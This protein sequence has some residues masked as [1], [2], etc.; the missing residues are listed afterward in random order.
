MQEKNLLTSKMLNSE[1]QGCMK[2][3]S[4][5][6]KTLIQRN[7]IDNQTQLTTNKNLQIYFTLYSCK[8]NILLLQWK[9]FVLYFDEHWSHGK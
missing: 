1:L 3:P 9:H 6:R 2:A 8:F 5:E 7:L 4:V